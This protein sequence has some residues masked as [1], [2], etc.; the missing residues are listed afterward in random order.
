L[1]G[2]NEGLKVGQEHPPGDCGNYSRSSGLAGWL[3]V[4]V[5]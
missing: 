2:G 3:Q 5:G 1:A 4:G